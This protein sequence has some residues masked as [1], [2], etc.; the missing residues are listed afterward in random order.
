MTYQESDETINEILDED[1]A[2][3]K[4]KSNRGSCL[5]RV[6]IIATLLFIGLYGFV[7][8]RQRLLDLEA[9]AIV[10]AAQTGTARSMDAGEPEISISDESTSTETSESASSQ[11]MFNETPSPDPQTDR[12]A[13]IAA[14]LTAI[15]DFQKTGT[16][17]P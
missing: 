13:T 4:K 1:Q 16:P 2:K 8:F 10:R 12:T 15:A 9:E 3:N 17:E 14:Q 7:L 6:L 5:L 11:E